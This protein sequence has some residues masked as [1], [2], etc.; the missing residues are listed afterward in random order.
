MID[1][2]EAIGRLVYDEDLIYTF[3]TIL[4]PPESIKVVT[5]TSRESDTTSTC[6]DISEEKYKAVQACLSP[7][8]AEQHL[9]LFAAGE[10][11]W[12]FYSEKS[13]NLF[14]QMC[15]LISQKG[16]RLNCPS[17]SY[18]IALGLVLVDRRFREEVI[19]CTQ[20]LP[21]LSAPQR[22][23]IRA[24]VACPEFPKLAEE[25]DE[26]PWE[27]GCYVGEV[28]RIEYRHPIALDAGKK[29]EIKPASARSWA[30]TPV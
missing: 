27:Q 6:L 19:A 2:W 14:D 5:L 12:T 4:P 25:F 28:A 17:T 11:I 26:I 18:F 9:S 10:L 20:A 30:T 29:I 15:Q 22:D 3:K 13:R 21:R 7:V 23:H 8:L 1:Y 24:L 16:S